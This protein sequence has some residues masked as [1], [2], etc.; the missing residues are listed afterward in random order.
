[1]ERKFNFCYRC[2]AKIPTIAAFCTVC[3]EKQISLN[4]FDAEPASPRMDDNT[5]PPKNSFLQKIK[6]SLSLRPM[7]KAGIL[8]VAAIL[9]FAMTFLPMIHF[10][11]ADRGDI[12]V[13]L[14]FGADD[15]I[16]FLADSFQEIDSIKESSLIGEYIEINGII[17]AK[18]KD[19]TNTSEAYEDDMPREMVTLLQKMMVLVMRMGIQADIS[20]HHL[21][22][23]NELAFYIA[24][25]MSICYL[26]FSILFL[27]ISFINFVF[28]AFGNSKNQLSR[29]A[30]ALLCFSPMQ[31]LICCHSIA[32]AYLG[33][34][35]VGVAIPAVLAL[36]LLFGCIIGYIVLCAGV[37]KRCPFKKVFL[38]GGS[39]IMAV[40][41]VCSLFAP[42]MSIHVESA[43][44]EVNTPIKIACFHVFYE[45]EDV[46]KQDSTINS[47]LLHSILQTK[48][49]SILKQ[50]NE[51]PNTGIVDITASEMIGV[52]SAKTYLWDFCKLMAQL[53]LLTILI[54]YL[55]GM[56]FSQN[57][58]SLLTEPK[59]NKKVKLLIRLLLL[60]LVVLYM[61]MIIFSLISLNGAI[62]FTQ[63]TV[64]K[65]HIGVGTVLMF[66]AVCGIVLIP[67]VNLR[68]K[69]NVKEESVKEE[70]AEE[71]LYF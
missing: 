30:I 2:G 21:E 25:V 59:E 44:E 61:G 65:M 15:H 22:A 7:T 46:Y 45:L 9:T 33:F 40:L 36:V 27:V 56:V 50:S 54:A 31:I 53:P 5:L 14:D 38:K 55:F 70:S 58:V 49:E 10:G 23:E 11:I 16:L 60:F 18:Y 6:R 3:G 17:S 64:C 47:Q 37:E 66:A 4:S 63:T 42:V 71:G 29:W 20:T 62:R 24:G 39:A 51:D 43:T 12:F 19:Y 68:L 34:G 8:L 13:S 67:F 57:L 52:L 1:M 32:I 35:K 28:V 26:L 69:K 48:S 41:A